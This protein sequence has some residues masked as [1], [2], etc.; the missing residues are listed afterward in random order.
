MA[1]NRCLPLDAPILMAD[2]TWKELGKIKIGDKVIGCNYKTGIAEPTVVIDTSRAGKKKVYKVSF[3]QGGYVVASGE[4]S[5]PM[6]W[7]AGRYQLSHGRKQKIVPKKR[8]IESILNRNVGISCRARFLKPKEVH[9]LNKKLPLH[10]YLLGA[11]IGDG[12]LKNGLGFTNKDSAVISRVGKLL[13][14]IG[15]ELVKSRSDKYFYTIRSIEKIER[16]TDGTFGKSWLVGQIK[17]LGLRTTSGYKKIPHIYKIA[18]TE[19]R[20]QLLAGLIDTDGTC[21]EFTSKSEQLVK[22]FV[23]LVN[24]IGGKAN[25]KATTKICTNTGVEGTYYRCCYYLDK[26]IPLQIDYKRREKVLGSFN[27]QIKVVKEIEELNEVECGDIQVAHPSH[28]YISY[29]W[30]ITGNTGKTINGIIEVISHCLGYRPYLKKTDPDYFT[31]YKPPVKARIYGED[32]TEHIG[33]VIV[34][35]LYE[36]VPH[37]AFGY[38]D[39]NPKKNPQG[40]PTFWRFKNGSSIE[41]LTYEQDP[42]KSEG[43]EGQVIHF[44]EP[45]PRRTYIAAKRG[46][47]VHDGVCFF[48]LTPLKEPWIYDELWMREDKNVVGITADISSNLKHKRIWYGKEAWTGAL[49][50]DAIDKYE[51]DLTEEEK[52]ARLKGKFMHLAGLV[53]KEFDPSIHI[54]RPFDVKFKGYSFY[55]AIDPATRKPWAVTIMAIS[56]DGTKYI[57]DEIFIKGVVSDIADAINL[58]R[59]TYGYTP[60]TPTIIDPLAIAEDPISHTTVLNEFMKYNI[61][62]QVGSKDRNRGIQLLKADLAVENNRSGFYVFDNCRRTIEEFGHYVWDDYSTKRA[63]TQSNIKDQPKK[64]FDDMLENIHRLLISGIGYKEQRDTSIHKQIKGIGT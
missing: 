43:W 61:F 30:I 4:H 31:R 45:P 41:M 55:E 53:Y 21:E 22:D 33:G 57:V 18:D 26:P 44:D 34:P 8:K 28:T 1:A 6:L 23:F 17:R 13:N 58:K 32:F 62:C 48:T 2:G 11:L 54:I 51:R 25:Y 40:V 20:R 59:E 3:N 7:R 35:A 19:S 64:A 12:S 50:K 56:P 15:Y 9:F 14:N 29:D 5:F 60:T 10:P 27:R 49:T 46:L 38:K 16:N 37:S 63:R 42:A 47:V 39:G 24:S 52:E 36:W